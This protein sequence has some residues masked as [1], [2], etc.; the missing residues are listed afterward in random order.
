MIFDPKKAKNH[1]K[2]IFEKN[3]KKKIQNKKIKSMN[4]F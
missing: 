4:F 1:D 2:T 3:E